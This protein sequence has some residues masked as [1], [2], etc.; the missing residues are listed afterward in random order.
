MY[1]RKTV[2]AIER[3]ERVN[4]LALKVTSA[5]LPILEEAYSGDYSDITS[6]KTFWHNL[7]FLTISKVNCLSLNEKSDCTLSDFVSLK[8]LPTSVVQFEKGHASIIRNQIDELSVDIY[9]SKPNLSVLRERILGTDLCISQSSVRI[10]ESKVSRDTTGSYYTPYELAKAVV[11]KTMVTNQAQ[12]LIK[13]NGK[14]LKIAD[15]SCGGGEFFWATQEFLYQNWGIPYE[16]SSLLFWGMDVDPIALQ[17]TI[18]RLLKMANKSDWKEIAGHFLLGNP[19]IATESE[20]DLDH[21]NELFALNRIYAPE[22]GIDYPSNRAVRFDIILGNPPWEK[23][24]FEER[25]FFSRYYPEISTMSKK[26]ER[27]HAIANLEHGWSDLFNWVSSI[28]GDYRMMCSKYYRHPLIQTAVSGELNTYALFTE[29]AYA[30]LS[31]NGVCSLIVKS[32]LATAPAHKGLWNY[33]LNNNSLVSLYFFENK[34]KIFNIDSRERFAVIMLSKTGQTSFAFSAGLVRSADILSCT[35]VDVSQEDVLTINPFTK[36]L[37]NV[38]STA[39]LKVLIDIHRTLPLFQEI[40][41]DCHFGRLIHLTAHAKQI[42]MVQSSDNIPIYEGKFIEQYDGRYSTFSGMPNDKKYAAKATALKNVE[43]DGIKPLPESRYFVRQELWDKYSAQY[44]KA[45]SL[46]WRSLT[47]PTNARTTIAMILP[48][49]PTCQSIQMLQ[50]G[51]NEDLI[52]MLA[53]FNSIPFDYFVRLKMPGIDLTQSVIRQIPVPAK[54]RY[55]QEVP[56]NGRI[57]SLKTHIFSCVYHLLKNEWRLEPLLKEIEGKIY[58][59]DS[60]LTSDAVRKQLD[61]LFARAYQ[62]DELAFENIQKTF[63]KY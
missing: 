4:N 33:F 9:R 34:N 1:N 6:V 36:M 26:D 20:G 30:L 59:L 51:E 63:P 40:Y 61:I 45:Y 24:R 47:S 17:I 12:N 2:F 11:N 5:L 55:E 41:P 56:L 22:M 32:T 42:D 60:T 27:E 57:C 28:S 52:M 43:T 16:D 53:L 58:T 29:L 10:E 54:E 3:R 14:N 25:K 37:P 13:R 44:N 7:V 46:C 18:C 38:S 23:I 39:D 31:E 35:E 62:L 8:I 49:C 15:L 50:T 48:S 19:L 21:K